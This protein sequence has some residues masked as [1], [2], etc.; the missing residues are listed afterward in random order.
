MKPKKK[1]KLPADLHTQY[2][3]IRTGKEEQVVQDALQKP[4]VFLQYCE[5][6]LIEL[7]ITASKTAHHVI[8]KTKT[9]DVRDCRECFFLSTENT[10]LI[11]LNYKNLSSFPFRKIACRMFTPKISL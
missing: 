10:C 11:F 4:F 2:L 8:E 9:R 1:P 7:C 5:E 6:S 3:R